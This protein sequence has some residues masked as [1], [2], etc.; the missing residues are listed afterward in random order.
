MRLEQLSSE[1]LDQMVRSAT[2]AQLA[3]WLNSYFVKKHA[4]K[5]ALRQR[6]MADR[7]SW[8][9]RAGWGQTADRVAHSPEGLD[10]P[11]LL[12]RIEADMQDAAGA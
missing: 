8:A 10:L 1:A 4:D 2:V 5:E 11:A 12:D 6:W 3:D 9:A 7:N